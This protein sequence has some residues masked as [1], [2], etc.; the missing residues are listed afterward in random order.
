MNP[1]IASARGLAETRHGAYCP[2]NQGAR[3]S[4][5]RGALPLK[6][7]VQLANAA[8]GH[9]GGSGTGFDTEFGKHVL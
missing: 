4:D 7:R 5:W 6:L 3:T 1:W 9:S 2:A 8:H